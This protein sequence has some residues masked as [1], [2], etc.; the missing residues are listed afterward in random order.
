MLN[1]TFL[2]GIGIT[3]ASKEEVLEYLIKTIK[4]KGKNFYV[5]TPNPEFLVLA[6]KQNTFKNILNR[7]DLA[8]ND[9]VGLTIAAKILGKDLKERFTGV[10]FAKSVCER[11]SGQPITVGFLGGR[12]GVAEATAKCLLSSYPG[13]KVVFAGSEWSG[14]EIKDERLKKKEKKI[15]NHKSLILNQ[16][17]DLL[18]VAFG[19][20]KQEE[21]IVEHLDSNIYR[22]AVGVGGAFDYISGRVSR[23]PVFVQKVGLE[24]L[25]RLI[26]QP[27]RFKR[28]LALPQ[29]I[30][31]VLKEK[32]ISR[33]FDTSTK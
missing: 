23:A 4:K 26:V 5:V 29:F 9:G 18:F 25:F 28:Q 14:E 31:L 15:I 27:W 19:F 8:L 20:P 1:K 13:L 2:L 16:P 6:D 10:D 24:W 7:A 17:I 33:K 21:W 32:F 30:G 12:D 11:I 22:A 3:N